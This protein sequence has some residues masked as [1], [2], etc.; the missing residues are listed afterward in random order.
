MV[1]P[2]TFAKAI[3]PAMFEIKCEPINFVFIRYS[4]L[5]KIILFG[6]WIFIFDFSE[7]E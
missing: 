1:I 5:F 3:A 2:L 6:Y 7:D 4:V